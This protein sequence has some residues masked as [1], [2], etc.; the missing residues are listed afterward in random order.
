M[1]LVCF[2]L[3]LAPLLLLEDGHEV[4]LA[5]QS[6][7]NGIG[8]RRLRQRLGSA[9]LQ[10]ADAIDERQI[11]QALAG[12]D[13]LVSWFWTRRLP[14]AWLE[15]PARGAVGVHPSLLPRHRGPNPY[16]WTIESADVETGV[17]AHWLTEEYDTG[18]ILLQER[19][20]VGDRDSWQLARA[21][22]RPSLRVLRRV[23]REIEANHLQPRPQEE[24]HATWAP[25]P[26][27]EL[28][29]VDW[30]WPT[31]RVLRRIRALSPVPGLAIEFRGLRFFVTRARQATRYPGF[32]RP[33]EG[34]VVRDDRERPSA[35]STRPKRDG[36]LGGSLVVRTGDGAIAVE[37]AVLTPESG[38]SSEPEIDEGE[39]A[40]L[41]DQR[42]VLDSDDGGS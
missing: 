6:P 13:L 4:L 10:V 2:G 25:E 19:L 21:L 5:V 20:P 33:G 23:V 26:D 15:L 14:A 8:G 1:R 35:K 18:A 31:D 40:G 11:A 28:L 17:S 27:G 30:R 38:T 41:V 9:S 7:G 16:F 37:R 32:L 34:S 22:D 29:R 24:A 39:L 36:A 12:A 3:P 42:V